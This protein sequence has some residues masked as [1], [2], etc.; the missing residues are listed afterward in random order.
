MRSPHLMARCLPLA[1]LL[2]TT[3]CD[4]FGND[5]DDDTPSRPSRG[6]DDDDDEEPGEGEGEGGEGEG[7][8]GEGEGE[9]EGPLTPEDQAH[10]LGP[11]IL[12]FT[13]ST[14]TLDDTASATLTVV[15]SDPDGVADIV[16]ALLVDPANNTVLRP[17][18]PSGTP[19]TFTADV[20]WSDLGASAVTLDFGATTRRSIRVRFLDAAEH[21]ISQSLSFTLGCGAHSACEGRCGPFNCSAEG[22]C[23]DVGDEVLSA[24]DRCSFC[25][26]GCGSCDDG[27]ACFAGADTCSGSAECLG[28][29]EVSASTALVVTGATCEVIETVRR[30]GDGIVVWRIG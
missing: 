3:A 28:N 14:T 15:V 12:S 17:L 23:I 18:S 11:T 2:A 4:V 26:D 9:G 5:N 29:V 30:R 13:S 16:G 22:G 7:E 24:D 20:R 21:A 1:L 19:G 10:P 6:D 27:C 25:N 8:G